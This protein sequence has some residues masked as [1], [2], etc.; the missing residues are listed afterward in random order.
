M[1]ADALQKIQ[2]GQVTAATQK[3]VT[4]TEAEMARR[5]MGTAYLLAEFALSMEQAPPN[6]PL[7]MPGEPQP[8]VPVNTQSQWTFG[9]Q[10]TLDDVLGKFGRKARDKRTFTR[11]RQHTGY[12]KPLP[13][14]RW[15]ENACHSEEPDVNSADAGGFSAIGKSSIRTIPSAP[16]DSLPAPF[17]TARFRYTPP[18]VEAEAGTSR[19]AAALETLFGK[20]TTVHPAEGTLT[21]KRS[22]GSRAHMIASPLRMNTPMPTG[23]A[24]MQPRDAHDA[25]D[26]YMD[27]SEDDLDLDGPDDIAILGMTLKPPAEEESDSEEIDSDGPDEAAILGMTVKPTLEEHS[28]SD[29]DVD[30][31]GPDDAAILGM[32]G[33]PTTTANVTPAFQS[34]SHENTAHP[35]HRSAGKYDAIDFANLNLSEDLFDLSDSDEDEEF[36]S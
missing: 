25:G 7:I 21:P 23:V 17:T 26:I 20:A 32:S 5:R 2:E 19:H 8:P 14:G 31:D 22:K 6:A 1:H 35:I 28:D 11:G 4:D 12:Y 10:V 24:D 27:D 16:S 29:D 15:N 30:L 34:T 13:D 33:G 36:D 18:P 3:A 9:L